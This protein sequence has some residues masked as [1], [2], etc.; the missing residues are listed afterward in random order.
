MQKDKNNMK[1]TSKAHLLA[2]VSIFAPIKAMVL[3]TLLLIFF[4]L[5]TGIWAAKKRGEWKSLNDIKSAGLRRS[6]TKLFVY[7]A[8]I[9][10]GYL[11]E[12][13][14]IDGFVPLS[15]IAAGYISIVEMKSILENLDVINGSPIFKG[16]IQKLGSVNDLKPEESKPEVKPP[17]ESL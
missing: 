4:D 2:L 6:M 12:T 5:F 9:M 10:L 16:L 14:M 15:K 8:G 7:E 1:E 17:G 3:I 11:V 13:Y